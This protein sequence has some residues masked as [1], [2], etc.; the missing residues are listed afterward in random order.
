MS[1]F[2]TPSVTEDDALS[3]QENFLVPVVGSAPEAHH[4]TTVQSGI[5]NGSVIMREPP[6]Y[7]AICSLPPEY[8][9][10][11]PSYDLCLPWIQ[12]NCPEILS[13]DNLANNLNDATISTSAIANSEVR[14]FRIF[15]GICQY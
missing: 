1:D 12:Q 6:L 7:C 3:E 4:S 10:N 2:I 8:C 13:V 5:S 11:G 9:E 14:L 15:K